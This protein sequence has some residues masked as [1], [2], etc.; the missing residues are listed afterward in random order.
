MIAWI[1]PGFSGEAEPVE[2][3]LAVDGGVEVFDLEHHRF[4]I[5]DAVGIARIALDRR[6]E[7]VSIAD[8]QALMPVSR[9]VADRG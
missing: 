1:S 3:R 6:C 9:N 2:D 8:C 4:S 5:A 7:A